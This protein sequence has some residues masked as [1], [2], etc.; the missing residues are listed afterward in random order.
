MVVTRSL[1][2][3]QVR[4]AFEQLPDELL[5][6]VLAHLKDR[7]L[8]VAL[9]TSK[10]FFA[11]KEPVWREASAKRWPAWY[12]VAQGSEI[13]WRRQYEMLSLRERELLVLPSLAAIQKKQTVVNAQNRAVLTEWLAE[14]RCGPKMH[15]GLARVSS[16]PPLLQEIV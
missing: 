2:K 16:V 1:F 9:C 14:V 11:C 7:D 10:R 15:S 6:E 3:T 4:A 8:G 13:P 12:A 5:M